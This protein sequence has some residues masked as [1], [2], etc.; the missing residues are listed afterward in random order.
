MRQPWAR[1]ALGRVGGAAG[2]MSLCTLV[3]CGGS[4]FSPDVA[5]GGSD[6]AP[7]QDSA[8]AGQD[9]GV[10]VDSGSGRADSAV[11][12]PDSG[13][14]SSVGP[15]AAG[16]VPTNH[17]P[18]DSQCLQPAP[19]GDCTGQPGP[20]A[21]CADDSQC[22]MGTEGRCIN[23][24]FGGPLIGC[25]CTYD[26][27]A[28][29]VSCPMSDVCACHG[30]AYSDGA[31]NV[32]VPS[33]CRVDSDCGPHGYCSPTAA[34]GC[35]EATGGYYCHTSADECLDDSDC[36]GGISSVCAWSPGDNRWECKV[37][38]VCA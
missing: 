32:C 14:D 8:S 9:S 37:Q 30:S 13:S 27:C 5:D 6:G 36:M 25:S 7:R 4:V 10:A 23:Q 34:S 29:D 26:S 19:P 21:Q 12:T 20:N 18:D 28:S 2:V 35:A 15:D 17:R 1:G 24:N 38:P 31:G 22:T 33:N 11:P 16:R 3:A